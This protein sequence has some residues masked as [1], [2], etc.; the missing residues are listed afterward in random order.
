[1]DTFIQTFTQIIGGSANGKFLIYVGIALAAIAALP[2]LIP[3]AIALLSLLPIKEDTIESLKN[4]IGSIR[5]WSLV[6]RAVMA[7]AGI[8]IVV[9]GALVVSNAPIV[10]VEDERSTNQYSPITFNVLTNDRDPEG[11]RITLTSFS[12]ISANG[13]SVDC[14]SD[15][16]CTYSPPTTYVGVD[17]FTYDIT[18]GVEKKVTGIQVT[19]HVTA[20]NHTPTSTITLTR[21]PTI[22]DVPTATSTLTNTP[23]VKPSDTPTPT[24]TPTSTSTLTPTF[25]PTSTQSPTPT[26]EV[27]TA[28]LT[29]LARLNVR[30]GPGFEYGYPITALGFD[31]TVPILG[32]SEDGEWWQI[33]CPPSI[34]TQT[35][36]WVI[37]DPLYSR[38][39]NTENVPVVRNPPTPTPA[40]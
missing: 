25:T 35:G 38:T 13:G 36:C 29:T 10:A 6:T 26:F 19:I 16:A 20:V 3:T 17:Y 33:L 9:L 37:S 21:S 1:M 12:R 22:T 34:D 30:R 31:E 14:G 8:I 39:E 23:T 7:L 11:S 18:Y 40:G 15:G 28:T 5:G 27:G 4:G 24:S 2:D 32:K